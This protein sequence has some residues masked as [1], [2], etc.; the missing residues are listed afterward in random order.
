MSDVKVATG[1]R[2]E[3]GDDLSLLRALKT[4]G[5]GGSGL[6]I[7]TGLGSFRFCETGESSLSAFQRLEVGEP[8][9]EVLVQ[10][11]LQKADNFDVTCIRLN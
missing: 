1:L 11:V 4:H 2:R 10:I 6:L 5:E 9:I 8:A 7:G 3:T